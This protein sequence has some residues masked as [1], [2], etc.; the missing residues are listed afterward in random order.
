GDR[1]RA[2]PGSQAGGG[3]SQVLAGD[4]AESLS[5]F[6]G[7]GEA[8]MADLVESLDLRRPGAALGHHERPDGLNVAVSGLAGT[9]GS[10]RQRGPRGLAGIGGLRLAR[11]APGPA[12]GPVNLKLL[13]APAA[14]E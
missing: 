8:Q 7:G 6:V 9:L 2:R 13:P 3:G 14:E 4:T 12:V 11:S 10:A 5:Q 1:V